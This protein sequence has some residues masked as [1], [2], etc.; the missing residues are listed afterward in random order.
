MTYW[1]LSGATVVRI[2]LLNSVCRIT[3]VSW[4]R[5][6]TLRP[7]ERPKL[8]CWVNS[9]FTHKKANAQPIFANS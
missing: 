2:S 1:A 5:S 4:I 3:S 6:T 8:V 7:Q 9:I